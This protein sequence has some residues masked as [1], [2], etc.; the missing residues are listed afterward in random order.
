M[1]AGCCWRRSLAIDGSSGAS[2]GHAPVVCRLGARWSG[3][4]RPSAFQAGHIQ[5][6]RGLCDRYVLSPV[7]VASRW[8]LLSAPAGLCRP[9]V[10]G[11]GA[12]AGPTRWC[13]G[14]GRWI[15]CRAGWS[16]PSPQRCA[17]GSSSSW[18]RGLVTP[19]MTCSPARGRSA[20]PGP[21]TPASRRLGRRSTRRARPGPTRRTRPRATL[22]TRRPGPHT[23]P[24][25][26]CSWICPVTARTV[27]GMAP[28][29]GQARCLALG[30][31]PECFRRLDVKGGRR[32]FPK[33]TRSALDIEGKH[34]TIQGPSPDLSPA[35]TL[36]P[37]VCATW[38]P[39]L[40]NP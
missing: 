3:A 14:W 24:M 36:A 28:C 33:E 40:S 7:A 35:T 32:L 22:L 18:A 29:P 37:S 26:S 4:A 9:A 11:Q 21:P 25:P 34:V 2:R 39:S 16:A 27:Q 17:G 13:A 31:W 20:G 30:F 5:G 38:L 15:R 10:P 6:W 12:S 1:F 8:W 19:W 23:T